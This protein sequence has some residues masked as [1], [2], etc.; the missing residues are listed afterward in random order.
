MAF[1]RGA[2]KDKFIKEGIQFDP[3][4]FLMHAN[5]HDFTEEKVNVTHGEEEV[6]EEVMVDVVNGQEDN[7]SKSETDEEKEDGESSSDDEV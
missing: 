6:L 2:I 3:T 5:A 1:G 7:N 4:K